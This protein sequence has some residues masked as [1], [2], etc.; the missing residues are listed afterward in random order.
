VDK[1][2]AARS[3]QV[4]MQADVIVCEPSGHRDLAHC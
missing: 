4:S 3:D 2:E 1:G